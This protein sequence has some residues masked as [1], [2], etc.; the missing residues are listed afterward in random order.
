MVEAKGQVRDAVDIIYRERKQKVKWCVYVCVRERARERERERER[1]RG[2]EGGRG[3]NAY[4]C[5]ENSPIEIMLSGQ[6]SPL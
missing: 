4:E 6:I 2:R 5:L 3:T 1:E